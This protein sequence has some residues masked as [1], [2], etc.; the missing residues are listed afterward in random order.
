MKARTPAS[1]GA[2]L[3]SSRMSPTPRHAN[4]PAGGAL[5]SA[6]RVP[7]CD[8]AVTCHDTA[9]ADSG[10]VRFHAIGTAPPAG[11]VTVSGRPV[12]IFG[13]RSTLAVTV[14]AFDEPF[15]SVKVAA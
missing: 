2:R 10:A 14:I 7:P 8:R 6:V 3:S 12:A 1:G 15:L 9:L 5:A 4:A 13:V 11:M